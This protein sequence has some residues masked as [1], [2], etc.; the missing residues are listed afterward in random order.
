M[1]DTLDATQNAIPDAIV[2]CLEKYGLAA[3]TR[4]I[5]QEAGVNEVTLFRRFGGMEEILR[6]L[7]GRLALEVRYIGDGRTT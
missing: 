4:R 5:A 7:F 6:Q 3:P 1:T 2:V